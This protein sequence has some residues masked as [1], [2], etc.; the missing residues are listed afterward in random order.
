MVS[1]HAG[2]VE[3][4]DPAMAGALLPAGVSA[5]DLAARLRA[6]RGDM[7]GWTSRAASTAWRIRQRTWD[8]MAV[9]LVD[10]IEASPRSDAQRIPA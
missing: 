5:G 3:R 8:D 4:F 7:N 9:E 6:W 2:V 10:L 1:E